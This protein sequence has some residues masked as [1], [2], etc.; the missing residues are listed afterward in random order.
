ME[1]LASPVGQTTKDEMIRIPTVLIL[2]AGA[3]HDY[4]FPLARRLRDLVC[5]IP[6]TVGEQR[7]VEAGFD[8]KDLTQFV[9][10][11]RYSAYG[12]VDW[13][14]EQK[15]WQQFI[16]VAKAAIAAALIPFETVDRL[17]PPHAPDHDWYEL[18]VNTLD[19]DADRF[20]ENSLSVITFNYDRSLEHYLFTVLRTRRQSD[21]A[22]AQALASIEIIHVHGSLGK[23]PPLHRGGRPYTPTLDASMVRDAAKEIIVVGEASDDTAEFKRARDVLSKAKRIMFLGFG[24]HAESVRRLG[25]FNEKWGDTRQNEVS[26]SGTSRYIPDREY[27]RIQREV[28]NNAIPPRQRS[29]DTVFDFLSK[30]NLAS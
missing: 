23:L 2:G 29:T 11:L 18:L 21:S 24:F 3:S 6:G 14:L 8:H 30:A 12:S 27:Q 16:P 15:K 4:G 13:F 28:L 20:A 25:V 26:V 17:F 19:S 22:A 1:T 9:N 7:V 5:S 10:T